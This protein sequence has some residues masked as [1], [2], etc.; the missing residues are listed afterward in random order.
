MQM[1]LVNENKIVNLLI[2]L[3]QLQDLM[4]LSSYAGGPVIRTRQI[5]RK[6]TIGERVDYKPLLKIIKENFHERRIVVQTDLETSRILMEQVK[7][8]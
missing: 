1:K 7:K 4:H 3:F 8:S 6:L 2:G 5:S